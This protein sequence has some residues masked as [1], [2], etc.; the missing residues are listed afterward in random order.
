MSF[1][2]ALAFFLAPIAV[3][4]FIVWLI[5]PEVLRSTD[6]LRSINFSCPVASQPTQSSQEQRIAEAN[7]P[8][9]NQ[10]KI[11]YS[12]QMLDEM[13]GYEFEI[14]LANIYR[15]L[16][17]TV[18]RTPR[19]RDFGGDLILETE[20][21]KIIVQAKRT[22][23]PVSLKAVQEVS[24]AVGYYQATKGMVVTNSEFR[25]SAFQLA[26][27]NDIELVDRDE[28]HELIEQANQMA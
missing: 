22:K 11:T 16:G 4:Y 2:E 27:M 10:P 17:Y 15:R 18:T 6:N 26:N 25:D 8:P 12:L 14:A 28:L 20:Y 21:E 9:V 7:M 1:W 13:E 5:E 23:K 19:T 3:T 24:G